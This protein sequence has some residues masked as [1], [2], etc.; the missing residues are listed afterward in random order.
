MNDWL[1]AFLVLGAIIAWGL[2]FSLIVITI[3]TIRKN[4]RDEQN[5][6]GKGKGL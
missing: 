3:N 2:L 6:K 5:K 4:K 1:I